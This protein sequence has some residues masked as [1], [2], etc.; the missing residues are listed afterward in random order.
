MI[1]I[2]EIDEDIGSVASAAG[3]LEKSPSASLLDLDENNKIHQTSTGN[4]TN[5]NLDKE[6]KNHE[7]A[8][9][10]GFSFFL[11]KYT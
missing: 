9:L 10:T 4:I 8:G 3:D 1:G 5:P 7:S 11:H 6:S 2:E